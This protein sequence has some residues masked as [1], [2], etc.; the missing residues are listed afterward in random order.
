MNVCIHFLRFVKHFTSVTVHVYL[1]CYYAINLG[2]LVDRIFYR[3]STQPHI[4]NVDSYSLGAIRIFLKPTIAGLAAD[5]DY[6]MILG[7]LNLPKV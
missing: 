6:V 2:L 7:D 4:I 1:H 5:F 3:V